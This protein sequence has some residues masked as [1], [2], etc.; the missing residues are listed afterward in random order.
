MGMI[1]TA[2][3]RIRLARSS[4]YAR[5]FTL[6][7]LMVVM[8]I[9]IVL[10]TIAV[11]HY[12]KSY[13]RSKE[14]VLK[15]DLRVMREAIQDYT[16]DKEAAPNSLDDLVTGQYLARI[17]NDPM[18]G[19]PDWAPDNCDTVLTPDQTS[20]GICDVHSS[21]DTVSPFENTPYSSW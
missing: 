9:I 13:Q 14:A 3:V 12:E 4:G 2:K 19:K 18:T 1:S 20:T 5:G 6:I 11:G 10:A 16:R 8:A 21:S 7:E 15:T 17:P